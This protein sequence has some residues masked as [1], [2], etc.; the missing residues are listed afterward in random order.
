LL[1]IQRHAVLGFL[2][3]NNLHPTAEDIYQSLK[4]T[5]P[6]ISRATVY[7]TL[8]LFK[9]H[10]VVQEI[11]IERDKANYDY[12]IEPHYH[13]LCR[14]CS[15]VFD[16]GMN[17]YLFE[18]EALVNGHKVEEMRF[19]IIGICFKCLKEGEDA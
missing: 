10:G 1:T 5:Y 4:V 11:T 15:T 12:R 13:F 19:Y 17:K 16:V 14:R 18:R 9:Q 2:E 3:D 7:N 6:A 8:E